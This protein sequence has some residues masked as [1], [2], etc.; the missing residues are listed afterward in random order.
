MVR[1]AKRSAN[2]APRRIARDPLPTFIEPQLS[3]LM[4]FPPT[5][6]NW[7]HEIVR[8]ASPD[9]GRAHT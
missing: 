9:E 6:L 4:E 5:G 7:V 2:L 1:A 3:K 8:C